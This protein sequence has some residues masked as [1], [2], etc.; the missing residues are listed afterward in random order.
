MS[1]QRGG[2]RILW[3]VETGRAGL[4]LSQEGQTRGEE[5]VGRG[6]RRQTEGLAGPELRAEGRREEAQ[7]WLEPRVAGVDTK[8]KVPEGGQP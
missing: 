3:N 8:T 6:Q 7:A 4:S 5:R 1:D 2:P